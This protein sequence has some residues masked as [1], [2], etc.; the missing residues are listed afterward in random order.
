MEFLLAC[1]VGFLFL[2][3]ASVAIVEGGY[4]L[5]H[6]YSRLRFWFSYR[7]RFWQS[8]RQI[9]SLKRRYGHRISPRSWS[10]GQLRVTRSR[11]SEFGKE[12]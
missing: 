6:W 5:A 8:E 2:G 9:R 10:L 3:L 11:E 7:Y 1:L 4:L 12:K